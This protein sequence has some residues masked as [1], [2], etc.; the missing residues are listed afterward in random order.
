MSAVLFKKKL[1]DGRTSLRLRI[2]HKGQRWNES[3]NLY[4]S[5]GDENNQ[6]TWINAKELQLKKEKELH[7]AGVVKPAASRKSVTDFMT[8]IAESE[9][10]HSNYAQTLR[11]FL[12]YEEGNNGI[13]VLFR[14]LTPEMVEDFRDFMFENLKQGT[15]HTYFGSV[16]YTHLTLP[17]TERV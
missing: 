17:T 16:S 5:P 1:A 8:E 12:L 14:D 7:T 13:D 2:N 3:L 15:T 4:L 11:W 10:M 6:T 9:G